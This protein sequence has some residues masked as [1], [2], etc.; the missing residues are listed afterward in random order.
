[1]KSSAGS[2]DEGTILMDRDMVTA[3]FK[4][5]EDMVERVSELEDDKCS[6]MHL[7][8]EQRRTLKRLTALLLHKSEKIINLEHEIQRRQQVEL[9][10]SSENAWPAAASQMQQET[11]TPKATP[12]PPQVRNITSSDPPRQP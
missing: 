3:M 10:T 6:L 1:M 11:V 8:V 7:A 9:E 12:P 5:M 2:T 4:E